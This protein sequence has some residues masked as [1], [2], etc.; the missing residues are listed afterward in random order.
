MPS[1][2]RAAPH[3]VGEKMVKPGR[4]Q[5]P[6]TYRMT[7]TQINVKFRIHKYTHRRMKG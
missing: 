5:I 2:Q 3:T 6:R 4:A 1:A 7:Q